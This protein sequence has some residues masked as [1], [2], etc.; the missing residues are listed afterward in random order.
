MKK[1]TRKL[2]PAFAMLLISAVMLS[3]ASYAWFA[4][5][6]T[7]RASGMGVKVNSDAKYLMI[8]TDDVD[9][10]PAVVLEENN[11]ALLDLVTA[12][13]VDQDTSKV[14]N[15]STGIST[16]AD[17]PN[18]ESELTPVPNP[19]T[20]LSK[21]VLK[22]DFFVKLDNGSN[23]M[24]HNLEISSVTLTGTSNLKGAIRVLVVG[25]ENSV[26]TAQLFK[27]QV[28]GEGQIKANMIEDTSANGSEFLIKDIDKTTGKK[29]TVYIYYDG[30]DDSAYISNA[31]ALDYVYVEIA[32]TAV[33]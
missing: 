33:A 12:D 13:I 30:R 9:Y 15:W 10:K 7:V 3:T 31:N 19:E 8:S 1:S 25:E 32:F 24:L 16:E 5:N 14:V 21:Y 20:N 22:K 26:T 29:L 27:T 11:T 28:D 23:G 2:I 6:N 4:T 17:D 18:K